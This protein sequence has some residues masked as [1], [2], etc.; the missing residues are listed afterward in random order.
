[1]PRFW[2]FAMILLASACAGTPPLEAD[3]QKNGRFLSLQP[4]SL[5]RSLSLSQ[6]VTG[7]YDNQTYKMRYEVEIT[8]KR[9]AIVGLSPLGLTLFSLIQ[10]RG[11]TTIKTFTNKR[12][13]FDPRYTL[14]DLYLTHWPAEALQAALAPLRMR[15]DESSDGS[16]RRVR[17][18][19]GD[20]IAEIVYPA[21]YAK[22]GEIVIQHFDIPYR[23]RI[24]PLVPNDKR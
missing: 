15:I 22:K 6:L 13:V 11:Q 20:L 17:A 8:P 5:G 14:F 1:M 10:D 21:K 18:A 23:L 16:I 3:A 12:A 19:S 24:V 2:V 9:L 4:N 7:E